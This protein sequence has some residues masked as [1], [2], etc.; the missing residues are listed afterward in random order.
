MRVC[1]RREVTELR[2][3]LSMMFT[4]LSQQAEDKKRPVH[5]LSFSNRS[6]ISLNGQGGEE[7]LI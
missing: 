3:A 6:W 4:Y 2:A 5:F 7:S 1:F